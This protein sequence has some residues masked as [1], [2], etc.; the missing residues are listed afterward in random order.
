MCGAGQFVWHPGG[1]GDL[2]IGF[3]CGPFSVLCM[4]L[5]LRQAT[6]Y[7]SPFLFFV[8]GHCQLSAHHTAPLL[9]PGL[10]ASGCLFVFGVFIS[11]CIKGNA[12]SS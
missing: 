3:V 6:G 5:G 4:A 11:L 12:Q 9:S 2:I 10:P 8:D 1:F 7:T